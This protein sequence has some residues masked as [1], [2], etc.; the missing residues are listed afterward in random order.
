MEQNSNRDGFFE[1]FEFNY[2]FVVFGKLSDL[3][4]V[5]DLIHSTSGVNVRYETLDR[6]RLV[7]VRKDEG[8]NNHER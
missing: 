7:I 3:Q 5:R 4:K 8:N 1:N 6:G 2:A